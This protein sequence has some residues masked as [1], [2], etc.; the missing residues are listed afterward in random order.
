MTG[1][2]SAVRSWCCSCGG[3]EALA[4]LVEI[5]NYLLPAP[6]EVARALVEDRDLLAPDAW[7]T[8]RR[9]CSGSRSRTCA[10][11]ALAIALHL[12]QSCGEPCIPLWSP[13]RPCR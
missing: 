7:V 5:E 2:K 8:L 6:S 10:G 3:W 13:L 1:P 9:C 4:R 11:L 12:S